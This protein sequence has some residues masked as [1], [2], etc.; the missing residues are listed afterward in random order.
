MENRL[1]RTARLVPGEPAGLTRARVRSASVASGA[2][3][4]TRTMACARAS[5][6]SGST[7]TAASPTTS[8]SDEVFDVITGVPQAMASSAVRPK[9]SWSDGS[10]SIEA[11]R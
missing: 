11:C 8:G 9:P 10:S 2:S 1:H 3:V 5:V 7:R 4:N 6:S